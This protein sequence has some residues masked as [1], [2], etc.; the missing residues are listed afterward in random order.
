MRNFTYLIT[1]L[2]VTALVNGQTIVT[3][4]PQPRNAVLEIY[5]GV[6]CPNCPDGDVRADALEAAHPGRVVR[7]GVNSGNYAVP[8]SGQPD[9]RTVWGDSLDAFVGVAAY[10]SGDMNRIVWPDA[11]NAPPFFPQ[12]PP[13]NMAIRRPGWWDTG[14]PGQGAGEVIINNWGHSSVNIGATSSWNSSTRTITVL[15]E[16]YYTLNDSAATNKLNVVLTESNIIGYQS[17]ASS[18]YSHKDVLRSMITGA[19]G[20]VVSATT[21]TSFI[22]RTYTYVVPAGYNIDNCNVAIFVT[23]GDNTNTQTGAVIP[24]KNG[25]TLSVND[26]HAADLSFGV[27]PNPGSLTSMLTVGVSK[28]GIYKFEAIN[29]TGA[30]VMSKQLQLS[31]G[32]YTQS[33][34]SLFGENPSQ[35]LYMLRVSGGG[36]AKYC[37]F[38]LAGQ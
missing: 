15:V 31:Q 19:W 14:Y 22:S 9:F 36:E 28:S 29:M 11:Y 1:L 26:V 34:K 25:T 24:A 5:G 37:R 35:G 13:G 4:A 21:Q 23:R 17:G 8:S 7:I 30:V 10:P 16:L 38:L 33:L 2:F 6:N 18:T 32:V 12:N 20:D 27:Y 3:T